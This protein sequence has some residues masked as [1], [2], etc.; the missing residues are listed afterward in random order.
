MTRARKENR[1]SRTR[2]AA[3]APKRPV[4]EASH[5]QRSGDP[6]ASTPRK[7]KRRAAKLNPQDLKEFVPLG[8]SFG[9]NA[10]SLIAGP[11]GTNEQA[12]GEDNSKSE[13]QETSLTPSMNWNTG[14][15]ASIRVSLR[16]RPHATYTVSAQEPAVPTGN[17]GASQGSAKE[18]PMED[19]KVQAELAV[20]EGRRLYIGNL[21]YATTEADLEDFFREYSIDDLKIPV[22][23]RTSRS[24]GYAFVTLSTAD[25]AARAVE[26]LSGSQFADRKLSVQ[27][28]RP[29]TGT[30]EPDQ[31]AEQSRMKASARYALNPQQTTNFISRNR[32]TG[33]DFSSKPSSNE[34]VLA[35][36]P[37]KS[38]TEPGPSAHDPQAPETDIHRQP[39]PH[40]LRSLNS[41][42]VEMGCNSSEDEGGVLVNI[43]DDSEHESGEI[44]DSRDSEMDT[45]QE[46]SHGPFDLD[47]ADYDDDP[48]AD[49]ETEAESSEESDAMMDYANSEARVGS[50]SYRHPFSVGLT[51]SSPP[52]NLAQLDQGDIDLQLRYFYVGKGRH[53]VDLSEPVRCLICTGKGHM[54]AECDKL[55]CDRCGEHNAHSIWNCPLS[56]VCSSSRCRQPGHSAS[57]CPGHARGPDLAAICEMCERKGHTVVD[58]EL[59]W[60]TSGR[61]WESNL[62]DKRI[63]FECYE[64]GGSG[65]L[66][67]DCRFRRP[68]KRLGSTSWTYHQHRRQ[69]ERST[70]G[71]SIKGRAQ[72]P[73]QEPILI[74]SSDDEEANF[75]RPRISGPAPKGQIRVMAGSGSQPAQ[76]QSQR[77]PTSNNHRQRDERVSGR[78]RSASPRRM[79]YEVGQN[80]EYK[81][82]PARN[83]PPSR[84]GPYREGSLYQQP[85]LPR[86]PPPYRRPSPP[87]P[88]EARRRGTG[89]AYRPMPSSARQAWIQSRR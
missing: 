85:P 36:H 49:V 64:C 47:G 68:G 6:S 3:F 82:E 44:T 9:A 52:R 56:A 80:Y 46:T 28:A 89:E 17:S 86:E 21:A 35:P 29:G 11:D 40:Q 75:R 37:S 57:V 65:H 1:G 72:Q 54:A 2:P 77:Q 23:P 67:N 27:F 16:E 22:N 24:L 45:H 87:S 60:R 78:Q 50:S 10:A 41:H 69:A 32:D 70:Q 19:Y 48:D 58:C 51:R 39:Y 62:E 88:V 26:G 79:D 71:I 34:T 59:R 30:D 25:E 63:R 33:K 74:D 38:G 84:H 4:T 20:A 14:A 53:E 18:A 83:M 7:R 81:A 55:N 43:Q 42:P 61:P 12:E 66:G 76:S 5:H 15:K 8:G 13:Q 31:K 73:R